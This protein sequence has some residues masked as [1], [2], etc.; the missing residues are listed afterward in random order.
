[1]IKLVADTGKIYF[2]MIKLLDTLSNRRKC[3]ICKR[4]FFSYLPVFGDDWYIKQMKQYGINVKFKDM[5]YNRWEY[6]CPYCGSIDRTRLIMMYI[7]RYYQG[8]RNLKVLYFAPTSGGIQFLKGQMSQLQVDSCDLYKD[9][10]DY[11]LDIQDMR[12]IPENTYDLIICSHVLEHVADDRKALKELYRITKAGGETL[13]LVPQDLKRIW[14]DEEN[15]L[16][17]AEN[18]KR[19]GQADHVRRYTD[20][21]M[22]NR[23]GTAG[24]ACRIFTCDNISKEN[25]VQNA[26]NKNIR[27]YIARKEQQDGFFGSKSQCDD[28]HI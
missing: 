5:T 10:V 13:I 22:K 19:F 1:M 7:R 3:F 11:N 23:I 8:K 27:I 14:F 28:G 9:N 21:E 12:G 2:D 15:G 18:W 4:T 17:M 24:F 25:R 20:K 16:S 6:R 26:I